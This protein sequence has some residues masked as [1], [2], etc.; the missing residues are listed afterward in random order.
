MRENGRISTRKRLVFLKEK[1]Q[2]WL[3]TMTNWDDTWTY[4]F[5]HKIFMSRSLC[6]SACVYFSINIIHWWVLEYIDNYY[7]F[8]LQFLVPVPLVFST[9]SIQL[10]LFHQNNLSATINIFT[11]FLKR[12]MPT[13]VYTSILQT[14]LHKHST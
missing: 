7:W 13:I 4:K 14:M 3:G 6:S 10:L 2:T 8:L 11:T 9:F 1:R 12:W 5:L